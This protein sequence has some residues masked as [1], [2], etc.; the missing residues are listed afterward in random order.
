MKLR[1][2]FTVV[3]EER[4]SKK[5]LKEY[6]ELMEDEPMTPEKYRQYQQGNMDDD[7]N[8]YIDNYLDTL[9]VTVEIV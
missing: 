7:G 4:I 8:E 1:Y 2:T 5:E 9:K 3:G 6:G